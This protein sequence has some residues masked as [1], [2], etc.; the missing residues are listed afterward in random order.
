MKEMTQPWG[1]EEGAANTNSART[2]VLSAQSNSALT[3]ANHVPHLGDGRM[4]RHD[5][6]RTGVPIRNCNQRH[7]PYKTG[8]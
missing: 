1:Q 8:E 6:K 2:G 3:S 7:E 4:P 5:G